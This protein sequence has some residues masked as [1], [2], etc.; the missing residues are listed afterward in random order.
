MSCGL[1]LPHC[2]T[3]RVTGEEGLSPRGRI[4]AMRAVQWRDAPDR[5]RRSCATSR[6]ACSAGVA[7]RRARAACRSVTSWKARSRRSRPQRSI[8]PRSAAARVP[9]ARASPGAA[10]RVDAAGR[11][12]AAPPRAAAARIATAA[13]AARAGAGADRSVGIPTSWLFTGCVM[14]AWMRPTHRN[15]ATLVEA[16][17]RL[18]RGARAAARRAA[19]PCTCTPACGRARAARRADDGRDARRRRRSS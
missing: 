13:A 3:F 15:T 19:A 11:R 16:T 4:D 18:V 14:D 2:P 10:R 6:R 5:R 1:C 7:S 17:G 9:G 8:T 12:A